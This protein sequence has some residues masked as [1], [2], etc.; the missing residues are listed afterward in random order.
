MELPPLPPHETRRLRRLRAARLLDTPPDEVFDG[1]AQIAA[2]IAGAPMALVTLVDEGRQWFKARV[3]ID[4]DLTETSRDVSFCA[5]AIA[6]PGREPM[7]VPDATQDERF[8]DNPHV[9]GD[10]KVRF[11]AGFPL[12]SPEGH[13][14][15]TLCVM[16]PNARTLAPEQIATLA[17]VAERVEAEIGLRSTLAELEAAQRRPAPSTCARCGAS[18]A[19]GQPRCANCH[20]PLADS[21]LL[22]LDL[23]GRWRVESILGTGGIAQ[24]YRGRDLRGEHEHAVA[25]KLLLR[26][27]EHDATV[28][29]RVERE[30]DSLA[31]VSHPGVIRLIDRG[32]HDDLPFLVLELVDGKDLAEAILDEPTPA[33]ALRWIVDILDALAA[34]HA[35]GVVH[36]D[37]KPENVLL[38]KGGGTIKLIDFGLAFVDSDARL[39]QH[40]ETQG[41]PHYMSPEQCRGEAIFPGSDVYS[42]GAMLFELMTGV[43]PFTGA[44]MAVILNRHMKDDPPPM[45]SVGLRRA[46]HPELEKLVRAALAKKP[47]AR[48]SAAELRDALAAIQH[49]LDEPLAP[50]P[51]PPRT[52]LDRLRALVKK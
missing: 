35:A 33:V 14:L 47:G 39:T 36:R 8:H 22:G 1:F 11:Y 10:P 21:R 25:L 45:A 52:V 29:D 20:A 41:T 17:K 28:R 19:D 12:R 4:G 9:T 15:G 50:A 42:V 43:P 37:V 5:H 16:D 48:P 46:V 24:I 2:H 34:V 27:W 32:R 31:R 18:A 6:R 51:A 30:G 3:G 44:A 40:G 7:I 49:V 38:A 13:V 23:A 26:R